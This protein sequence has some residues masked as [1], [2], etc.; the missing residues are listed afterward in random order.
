MTCWWVLM[1]DSATDAKLG[2]D[3]PFSSQDDANAALISSIE[4][5][6][7]AYGRQTYG[8]VCPMKFYAGLAHE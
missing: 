8:V 4:H 5:Y 7:H 1:A 2:A 6:M 3:G